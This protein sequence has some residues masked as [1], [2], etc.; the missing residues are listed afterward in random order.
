MARTY[1]QDLQSRSLKDIR[2]RI[3]ENMDAILADI[4]SQ[5]AVAVQ[6]TQSQG[7]KKSSH[8]NFSNK[9][10]QASY[11]TKK[12]LAD[13]KP[14][15]SERSCAICNAAG[16][17]STCHDI[18]IC[19]LIRK[20]DKMK[21][22]KACRVMASEDFNSEEESDSDCGGLWGSVLPICGPHC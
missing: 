6:Y 10:H 20:I 18:K 11:N 19:R 2:P 8:S 5:E 17:P 12:N 3:S 15:H 21:I 4:N 1:A 16:R 22:A 13:K 9:R 14:S 7:R